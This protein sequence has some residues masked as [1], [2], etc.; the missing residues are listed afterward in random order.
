MSTGHLRK[1]KIWSFPTRR[2]WSSAN[3]R[4]IA[5]IFMLH[6]RFNRDMNKRQ[7]NTREK[8]RPLLEIR[9]RASGFIHSSVSAFSPH[10]PTPTHI[11]HGK[12]D[13][14]WS[15]QFIL[16]IAETCS[17]LSRKPILVLGLTYQKGKA[18]KVMGKYPDCFA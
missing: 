5:Q 17:P 9:E 2:S 15:H 4:H 13:T 16:E 10:P 3:I 18:N 11:H 14:S 1:K 8:A 7:E 12:M 6:V